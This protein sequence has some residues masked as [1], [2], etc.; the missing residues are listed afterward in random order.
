VMGVAET[1]WASFTLTEAQE[2]RRIGPR[3]KSKDRK[4]A[5]LT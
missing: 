5:R 2:A 4:G 3:E 1:S